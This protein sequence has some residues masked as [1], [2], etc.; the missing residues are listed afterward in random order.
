MTT[1]LHTE[2]QR[3]DLLTLLGMKQV[4][5]ERYAAATQNSCCQEAAENVVHTIVPQLQRHPIGQPLLCLSNP[6]AKAVQNQM[7]MYSCIHTYIHAYM[8][9]CMHACMHAQIDR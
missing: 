5:Q 1:H 2:A 8:H 9:M 7:Y 3:L 6:N 4:V